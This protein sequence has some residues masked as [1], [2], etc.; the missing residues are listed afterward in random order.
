MQKR[1]KDKDRMPKRE[2]SENEK[3][4][5]KRLCAEQK[6]IEAENLKKDR[7]AKKFL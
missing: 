2:K 6:E 3:D 7:A 5:Q 1:A 4:R